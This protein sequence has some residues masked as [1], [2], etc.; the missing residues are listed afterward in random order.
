MWQR[1]RFW[2]IGKV[3]C[4]SSASRS[5]DVVWRYSQE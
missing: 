5:I 4:P 3:Y 2:E 1:Q